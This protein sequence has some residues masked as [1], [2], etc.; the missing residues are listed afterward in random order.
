[1]REIGPPAD[2]WALGAILYELLTG[3]PPFRGETAVDTLVL[4]RTADPVPPHRLRPKVPRDLETVCLKCLQKEPPRR[5]PVATGLAEALRR[6]LSGVPVLARPAGPAQRL[7]RWCRRNPALGVAGGVAAAALV[8]V[9]AL[10][11]NFAVHQSQ[12]AG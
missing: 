10:A 2:V 7:I 9:V 8:A 1:N 5:Y 3:R 12:A 6:F 4:V 11:V